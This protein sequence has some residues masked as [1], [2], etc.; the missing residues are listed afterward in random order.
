MF[1]SARPW[2]SKTPILLIHG[3]ADTNIPPYHSDLI[4]AANPAMVV[5]WKVPG[6]RHTASHAAAP[7]EFERRGLEW[8]GEHSKR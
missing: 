8:F 3:L 4:Q 5:L 2:I 1:V 6:A 7:E